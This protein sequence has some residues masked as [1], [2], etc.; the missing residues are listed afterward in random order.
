VDP[1]GSHCPLLPWPTL[2][3]SSL[4]FPPSNKTLLPLP[5]PSSEVHPP[6]CPLL[7]PRPLYTPHSPSTS[8]DPPVRDHP[9][10]LLIKARQ[11]Y[12]YSPRTSQ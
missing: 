2:S 3:P 6:Y 10:R 1:L 8:Q 12:C 9:P 4:L 5:S 11:H 7:I